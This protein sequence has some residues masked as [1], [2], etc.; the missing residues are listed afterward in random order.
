MKDMYSFD[1]DKHTALKTYN[2]V[3]DAYDWFFSSIGLPF[4]TVLSFL[5]KAKKQVDAGG[6][7]IGGSICHEYHYISNGTHIFTVSDN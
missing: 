4:V 7:N 6:G 1:L 3:R 2:S 5:T